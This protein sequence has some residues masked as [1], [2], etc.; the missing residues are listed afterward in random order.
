MESLDISK[1]RKTPTNPSLAASAA[2]TDAAAVETDVAAA[3]AVGDGVGAV[4]DP[5]TGTFEGFVASSIAANDF[6]T[7][8]PTIKVSTRPVYSP[9]LRLSEEKEPASTLRYV[10]NCLV[11]SQNIHKRV[12]LILSF[13]AVRGWTKW[14][15]GN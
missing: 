13:S 14:P 15:Q 7:C 8:T 4:A 11:H 10:S 1:D 5:V 6:G 3:P 9:A 12:I 2:A